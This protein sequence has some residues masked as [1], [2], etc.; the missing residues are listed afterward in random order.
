M[1]SASRRFSVVALAVALLGFALTASARPAVPCPRC[2][3]V[4]VPLDRANP[5]AGTIDIAYALVPR[6]DTTRP[7]LG[8]IVPN[9]GAP[10]ESTIAAA[11]RYTGGLAPRLARRDL[12]LI[13]PRGT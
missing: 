10:G 5:S 8:T 7:A 6:T 3:N 4:T 2:A 9:P 11:G 12:L 13:D 1:S